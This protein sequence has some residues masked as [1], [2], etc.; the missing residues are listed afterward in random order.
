MA[1]SAAPDNDRRFDPT[2]RRPVRVSDSSNKEGGVRVIDGSFSLSYSA[3]NSITSGSISPSLGTGALSTSP[4]S[5]SS[6]SSTASTA[7]AAYTTQA[8]SLVSLP[9][10]RPGDVNPSSSDLTDT[11]DPHSLTNINNRIRSL[12]PHVDPNS[13]KSKLIGLAR[14]EITNDHK[15]PHPHPHPHIS[16]T[17]LGSKALNEPDDEVFCRKTGDWVK[18][19]TFTDADADTVLAEVGAQANTDVSEYIAVGPSADTN[20]ST[21]DT[22]DTI[23]GLPPLGSKALHEENDETLCRRIGKW[24]KL[25][26]VDPDSAD[27]LEYIAVGS[28]LISDIPNYMSIWFGG[29]ALGDSGRSYQ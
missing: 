12:P 22:V 14:D 5:S 18:L 21:V 24:M 9:D 20:A 1:A 28:G 23:T 7:T 26:D 6:N 19:S 10:I 29:Y 27:V 11:D 2:I 8:T 16:S 15:H 3:E 17:S 4:S 13:T 25:Q